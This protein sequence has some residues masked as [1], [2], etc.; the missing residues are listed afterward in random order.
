MASF[1]F[2]LIGAYLEFGLW[3]LVLVLEFE[4]FPLVLI[5]PD[6]YRDVFWFLVLIWYLSFGSW[7]LFVP[8]AIGMSFAS[9]CLFSCT[10]TIF[11]VIGVIRVI[12]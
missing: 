10:S 7:R 9:W 1:E 12:I 6:S 5:C 11:R 2:F 3:F 8:I 4:F